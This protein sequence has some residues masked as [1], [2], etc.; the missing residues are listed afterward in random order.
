MIARANYSARQHFVLPHDFSVLFDWAAHLE[1]LAMQSLDPPY[2]TQRE[3]EAIATGT[4]T[5]CLSCIHH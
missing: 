1:I 5:V 3:G 2:R 4:T